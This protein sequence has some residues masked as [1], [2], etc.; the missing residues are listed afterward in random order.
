MKALNVLHWG[1]YLMSFIALMVMALGKAQ[2][3][4]YRLSLVFIG[5]VMFS[6][7]IRDGCILTDIQNYFRVKN[8]YLPLHNGLLGREIIGNSWMVRLVVGAIGIWFLWE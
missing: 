4:L 7:A 2:N 1:I 3:R 8:G 6:Q 5:A